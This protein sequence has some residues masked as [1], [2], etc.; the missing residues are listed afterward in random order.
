LHTCIEERKNKYFP[1]FTDLSDLAT[2]ELNGALKCLYW[3]TENPDI[4]EE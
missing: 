1:D 2:L 4:T 3:V